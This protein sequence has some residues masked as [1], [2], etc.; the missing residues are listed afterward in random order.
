MMKIIDPHLHL[1]DLDKGQYDWLK[2]ENP[3]FW[4]DK[5]A[6]AN[7]FSEQD[8]HL[9]SPLKLAGFVHIEAGF[10][11]TNTWR[12][13]E[14][15]EQS[16]RVDFRSVAMLDIT[17]LP[18]VFSQQLTKLLRYKS[19][20]GIRHILDDDALAILNNGNSKDNLQQLAKH[21]LSF[22]LQLPITNDKVTQQ[23]LKVISVTP[24]LFYCINHAGWPPVALEKDN[25]APLNWQENIKK[26]SQFSNVYIKCS[27]YEMADRQY[28]KQ[29]QEDIISVCIANFGIS[30]VMLASN[31]PLNLWHST[32]QQ[33][34]LNHYNL[35]YS[36]SELNKLCYQNSYGF[37]KF[38]HSAK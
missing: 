26:L 10:D 8:I 21:K 33:N 37:Y 19:V 14:W 7:N 34:W 22:E 2:V 28:S 35:H 16:C 6:I 38:N 15:L 30:R 25:N 9:S 20:V 32:Y 12:E 17:L 4:P 31:F 36:K 11:N 13:I 27:G 3:P 29:W 23:L 24:E 1:F 18:V 5:A